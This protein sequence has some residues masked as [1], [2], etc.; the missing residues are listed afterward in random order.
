MITIFED[1]THKNVMFS[2]LTG[3][4]MIQANQHVIVHNGEAMI[5][6][7]GGHKVYS[8]LF[9]KVS[10]LVPLKNL[11]GI[12]FSHQDPDIVASANA[13]LMV[14]KAEAYISELWMRF[15]THFG[16]DELVA[17]RIHPIPDEGMLIDLGGVELKIVPAHFLHSAGN[18]QIYDPYSRV[19]YSGDLEASVGAPYNIVEDFNEHIQYMEGFRR[20]YIP[21]QKALKMWVNTISG[22]DIETIAPQHGAVFKGKK[23]VEAFVAWVEGLFC[24][25]DVMGDS[26]PLP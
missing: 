6:D 19:L 26:F 22:L 1:D 7:P 4:N 15:I 2:D 17:S 23:Q 25:V 20:R 14:S 13:W 18:F 16:V 5:L 10:K 12:F 24:G 8:K 11:K 9:A 21:C 3:K